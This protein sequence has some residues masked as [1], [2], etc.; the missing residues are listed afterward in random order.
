MTSAWKLGLGALLAA[1]T[2]GCSGGDPEL[3]NVRAM[4]RT[5]DEF[6]ILPNK[7]LE[8]P[9]NFAELPTP[10]PGTPSRTDPTPE[11]DA[12]VA[13]GGNPARG[14]RGDQGMI[15]YVSRYGVN[16]SIRQAVAAEDLEYRRRHDG[17]LLERWFNVN[18]YFRAYRPQSLDQYAELE[19]WR[20]LGVRNVGAPPP[21]GDE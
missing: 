18:V 11:A 1:L 14:V 8:M 13:L 2:S 12:I 15:N 3:M 20:R 7:P 17:R 9:K 10:A 4:N 5:P 21:I 6:A 19:R 16:P